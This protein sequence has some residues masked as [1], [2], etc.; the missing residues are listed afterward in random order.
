MP[1]PHALWLRIRVVNCDEGHLELSTRPSASISG[2]GATLCDLAVAVKHVSRLEGVARVWEMCTNVR[3]QFSCSLVQ[4]FTCHVCAFQAKSELVMSA[5]RSMLVD[6]HV[7]VHDMSAADTVWE[8]FQRQCLEHLTSVA[9]YVCPPM[10]SPIPCVPAH[11]AFM[12]FQMQ[13]RCCS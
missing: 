2:E 12:Y 3:L 5:A 10:F 4:F 11:L 9:M 6:F 13:G 7:H 1:H 8:G